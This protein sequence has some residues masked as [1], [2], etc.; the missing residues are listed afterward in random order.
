M[1][2]APPQSP[3]PPQ[4]QDGT[5]AAPLRP[6]LSIRSALLIM[7][8]L[9][10][11]TSSV[12]VGFIGF[13]NGRESL[14]E[15][16]FDRLTEVRD[17][18]A[19]EIGALYETIQNNLL[20]NARGQ[21]VAEAMQ[22]F[23]AG[24]AELQTVELT[25]SERATL[26]SYFDEQFGTML[27]EV[28]GAP[29]D[30]STFTP[31]D[32]AQ[33]YLVYNY[34]TPHESFSDA[35]AVNNAGDGSAWSAAHAEHHDFFRRMTEIFRYED[36]MLIDANGNI[37][38]T[39][40]KGVDLGS[41]LDS[42][43]L[44]RTNLAQ[45]Y[46]QAMTGNVADSVVVTDFAP[47]PPSLGK[48]ASWA[49]TPV[50][51]DGEIVGALAVEMPISQIDAVMTGGGDW[52]QGGL[53]E[54]GETYI[55]GATDQLMRSQSRVLA[56]NPARF[57]RESVAAGTSPEVARQAVETQSPLLLQP[58]R[59]E[60]VTSAAAGGVG[61][62]LAASYLGGETIAAY[63]PLDI[64]GLDW[65]IVAELE[66]DEALAPVEDFTRNLVLSSAVIVLLVSVLSLVIAGAI[67]R[68]LRRLRDAA[69]RIAAGETGVQVDA[70]TSYEL[71]DVGAA[72][73]DM[74]KSLQVKAQLLEE[75]QQEN[76]RLLLSLMPEAL[77]KRYKEGAHTIALDHQEVTVMFADIVGF[78]AFSRGKSSEAA[79]EN[80]NEILRA[81]DEAADRLGIERVR[82][83][84]SGYLTSCG[85]IVPRVDNARR[86]V[87]F[88][89][90]LERI[91][92]RIGGKYGAELS[93]RA[94]IDTGTATSGLIGQRQISYD[95]WGDAVN[96][97]F[98]LQSGETDSGIFLTQAV[99][100]RLP[101]TVHVREWGTLESPTGPQRIWRVDT[102]DEA[103]G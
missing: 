86:M 27:A 49:V 69:R 4:P 15:A 77:A 1:T 33:A 51:I 10:S 38:Y 28:N 70:G 91:L 58:A 66:S 37:V 102:D 11:I 53:G 40:F 19:R 101:D 46:A 32:P 78:E 22:L 65:V 31:T 17:S 21:S 56:E 9:V 39:A 23:S 3:A 30:A 20:I 13:V 62:T 12:V 25:E 84:R 42:G 73:N 29:V 59:T 87:E 80:L 45:A 72:F 54:T 92:H 95:L 52:S 8:L 61:T 64:T 47:Y 24:F 44:Q 90:Q 5:V 94:G 83:T 98:Q 14:R 68:P 35:I 16:A 89:V 85:L 63:A 60:A 103:A 18:R 81:F 43:P 48:P 97:A 71:A 76:E 6:G 74:S 82:S 96:L 7:L 36:V 26:E 67:V 75:Q 79:L 2:Q 34:T 88:A 57:E 93:L 100:D 99:V 41:N 50:A 55:V